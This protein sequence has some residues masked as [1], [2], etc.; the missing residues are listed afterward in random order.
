MIIYDEKI[1]YAE[2]IRCAVKKLNSI[3]DRYGIGT[4][5]QIKTDD[6]GVNWLRT[7]VGVMAGVHPAIRQLRLNRQASSAV[8]QLGAIPEL[9]GP[10]EPLD[11]FL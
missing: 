6:I 2:I 1:K 9:L 3:Y 4:A 8:F 10:Q 5:Y 7:R 11:G